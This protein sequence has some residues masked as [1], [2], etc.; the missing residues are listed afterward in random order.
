MENALSQ[1][2]A[3]P[4]GTAYHFEVNCGFGDPRPTA[5]FVT[6]EEAIAH[7]ERELNIQLSDSHERA[8]FAAVLPGQQL[9]MRGQ[10]LRW[11]KGLRQPVPVGARAAL[12]RRGT[13]AALRRGG[14]ADDTGAVL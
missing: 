11:L 6:V 8:H 4:A 14:L 9:R 10:G 2:D 13:R 3:S 5:F 7:C 1:P 12:Q